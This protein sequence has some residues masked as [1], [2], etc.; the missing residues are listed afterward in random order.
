MTFLRYCICLTLIIVSGLGYSQTQ[1]LPTYSF[2]PKAA[3]PEAY[4]FHK[5]GD[6][7]VGKFTGIPSIEVPITTIKLGEFQLPVALTYHSGGIKV[8]E[9]PSVVGIGW[10]LQCGGVI[11]QIVNG[12]NDF[13]PNGGYLNNPYKLNSPLNLVEFKFDSTGPPYP[14]GYDYFMAKKI[15]SG[16]IDNQPDIFSYSFPGG[17]GKFYYDQHW[18]VHTVPFKPIKVYR[19]NERFRI[20]DTDGVQYIFGNYD[21]HQVGYNC[22]NESLTSSLHLTKILIPGKDSIVYEYDEISYSYSSLSPASRIQLRDGQT[23]AGIY[24]LTQNL[25]CNGDGAVVTNYVKSQRLKKVWTSRGDTISYVYNTDRSDLPGTKALDSIIVKNFGTII[26][27][28]K[29]YHSYT[30]ATGSGGTL[31]DRQRLQLDSVAIDADFR[32]Y[33]FEY[34]PIKLPSRLSKAVDHYGYYN[35][36]NLNTSLLPLDY[37]YGFDTGGDREVDSNYN[38]AGILTKLFYPTGGFTEFIY[39]TNR[40]HYSGT[41]ATYSPV[42]VF[43]ATQNNTVTEHHFTI[44]AGVT[45]MKPH[46]EYDALATDPGA[47]CYIEVIGPSG[48]IFNMHQEKSTIPEFINLTPGNYTIRISVTGNF[49]TG[50]VEIRYILKTT[51]PYEGDKL[52]GGLRIKKII[53]QT[54]AGDLAASVRRFEYIDDTTNKSSGKI[55][56]MPVYVGP[57]DYT[58]THEETILPGIISDYRFTDHGYWKQVS[59]PM[60]PINNISGMSVGYT[61]VTEYLGDAGE[62]GKVR[63]KFS[64]G[65]E[66]GGSIYY[67]MVQTNTREWRN[68]HLLEEATFKKTGSSFE[69]LSEVKNYYSFHDIA[70]YWNYHF[71]P[72]SFNPN[73]ATRNIGVVSQFRNM[74]YFIDLRIYPATFRTRSYQL[75]S[76]WIRLDSTRT[77]NFSDISGTLSHLTVYNYNN[78][79]NMQATHTS[80]YSSA[81]ETLTVVRTYPHDSI[82]GLN[83]E[84]QQAKNA[85]KAENRIN[86]VLKEEKYRDSSKVSTALYK[87]KI[88]PNV[89]VK[90]AS[91]ESSLGE[92]PLEEVARV[93]SI[94]KK[95][96]PIGILKPGGEKQLNFW[97]STGNNLIASIANAD[98]MDVA[99]TSFESG[100]SVGWTF[101]TNN[102]YRGTAIAGERLYRLTSGNQISKSGLNSSKEY[103]VSFWYSSTTPP[104]VSGA[105]SGYPKLIASTENWNLFHVKISGVTNVNITGNGYIDDLR[106]Y[107]LNAQMT[108]YTHR[109]GLGIT[110]VSDVNGFVINYIYDE[111]N[112][113][114]IEKNWNSS[115]L[116]TYCFNYY[117]QNESCEYY[118]NDADSASFTPA[119]STGYQGDPIKYV[120]PSGRYYSSISKASANAMAA[121]DITENGQQ[122]ANLFGTCSPLPVY[123]RLEITNVINEFGYTTGDASIKFYQ[124]F[125]CTIPVSV[126]GLSIN[127]RRIRSGCVSGSTTTN[128]TVTAS[129]YSHSLGT[130]TLAEDDGVI[131]CNNYTYLVVAGSGY[132]NQVTKIY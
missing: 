97:D 85:L 69:L 115:I 84:F 6:I 48:V 114:L 128:Y 130:V 32:K 62:N 52:A 1:E 27:K 34:N 70:D 65:G 83:S 87:H 75:T 25:E 105:S 46:I 79:H 39:E 11:T 15:A 94:N 64:F 23:S 102:V 92:Y 50:W 44:P 60:L 57:I 42:S 3:T 26:S 118:T 9:I 33:K 111:F 86:V 22:G 41:K 122:Y 93:T 132:I 14:G 81:N 112:R 98:S 119:C 110:S 8:D 127:Y 117:T 59:S 58:V 55:S 124:D 56:F 24:L 63:S 74:E 121:T 49:N 17:T 35:G 104:S 5:Y 72:S 113:L 31:A 68:G 100:V 90:L 109:N 10:T 103:I 21:E 108:T 51:E 76:N 38:Q 95:G 4:S 53:S 47:D 29:L 7:P 125:N 99:Y 18:Q 129:G 73:D 120:V 20:V 116:K 106:L 36:K 77:T 107:P 101:N 131:I 80:T 126:S 82:P 89:G 13:N 61:L 54:H 66:Y 43:Q 12:L 88:W 16:E 78:L 96:N 40:F 91:F 19:E 71:E 30:L 28:Y 2:H 123:A 67:P 45:V 37:E